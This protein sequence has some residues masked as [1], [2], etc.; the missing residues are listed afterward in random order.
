MIAS[1]NTPPSRFSAFDNIPS[2]WLT[3]FDNTLSSWLVE[4]ADS[5]SSSLIAWEMTL[6]SFSETILFNSWVSTKK[7]LTAGKV[8][9][10]Q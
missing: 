4:F 2:S 1:N 5:E 3:V 7:L 10:K 9:T 8:V 6:G